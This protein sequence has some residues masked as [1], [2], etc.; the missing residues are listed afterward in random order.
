MN[1]ELI[2]GSRIYREGES[3]YQ[4]YLVKYAG[5]DPTTGQSLFWAK[6]DEGNAYTTADYAVASNCKEATGDLLPTVYG[7]FG[8]SLDFYGFDFSIQF[9]YQL[10]VNCGIILIKT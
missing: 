4:L 10:V 1:G 8:T 7:G 5:V 9:S 3:M 2:S 6:D